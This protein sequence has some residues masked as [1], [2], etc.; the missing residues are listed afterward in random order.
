MPTKK[1]MVKHPSKAK[2]VR[3]EETPAERRKRMA[4]EKVKRGRTK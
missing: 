2:G 3:P 4:E 1:P